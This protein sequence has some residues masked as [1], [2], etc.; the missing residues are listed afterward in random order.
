MAY[1]SSHKNPYLSSRQF[2][3]CSKANLTHLVA[4]KHECDY[5]PHQRA[6]T[7]VEQDKTQAKGEN[8]HSM[9]Y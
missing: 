6:K 2:F 4:I 1:N 8:V 7:M 9:S 5:T 3:N